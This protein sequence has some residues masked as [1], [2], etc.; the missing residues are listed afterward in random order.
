MASGEIAT[1]ARGRDI[2]A[3][4]FPP[5]RFEP[6][7]PAAW[8]RAA[9]RYAGIEERSVGRGAAATAAQKAAG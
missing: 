6:R 1:L 8:E 5:R 4:S 3:R 7:D 2:V 9:A